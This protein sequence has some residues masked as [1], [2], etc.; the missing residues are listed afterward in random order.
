MLANVGAA[1][2]VLQAPVPA[3]NEYELDRASGADFKRIVKWA[4]QWLDLLTKSLDNLKAT[5]H[6]RRQPLG[7]SVNP[8]SSDEDHRV[9]QELFDP[10]FDHAPDLT[11]LDMSKLSV[12]KKPSRK[13]K[14][15]ASYFAGLNADSD[16]EEEPGEPGW[17][18]AS[19]NKS[20]EGEEDLTA[21]GEG[22]VPRF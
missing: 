22:K 8:T 17:P 19:D 11:N 16:D 10:D 4:R 7:G 15:Q 5:S 1:T 9:D 18:N 20:D 13:S 14:A 3:P 2:E 12:H 6:E 21:S